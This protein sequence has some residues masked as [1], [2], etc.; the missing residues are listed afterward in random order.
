MRARSAYTATVSDGSLLEGWVAS[1]VGPCVEKAETRV[2]CAR[3]C[4]RTRSRWACPAPHTRSL[5]SLPLG[6]GGRVGRSRRPKRAQA[7]C[8]TCHMPCRCWAPLV[9]EHNLLRRSLPLLSPKSEE[10][11]VLLRGRCT[12]ALQLEPGPPSERRCT[13][14]RTFVQCDQIAG[15]DGHRQRHAA[16][17]RSM[18]GHWPSSSACCLS[19]L[20][21]SCGTEAH[22]TST[23]SPCGSW[24]AR[25]GPPQA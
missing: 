5:H 19:R 14:L 18:C 10:V 12:S 13:V 23:A 20:L 7:A 2:W 3:V 22:S 15:H 25:Q 24:P 4:G 1:R 16:C 8:M 9:L 17:P 11:P 6:R 21:H